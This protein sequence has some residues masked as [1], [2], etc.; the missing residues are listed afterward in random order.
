MSNM[1]YL[2]RV[3][4]VRSCDRRT[5]NRL[6]IYALGNMSMLFIFLWFVLFSSHIWFFSLHDKQIQSLEESAESLRERCLKFY[7]GCRKYTYVEIYIAFT[8][9]LVRL[10]SLWIIYMRK[11]TLCNLYVGCIFRLVRLVLRE[12]DQLVWLNNFRE[13]LDIYLFFVSL[14]FEL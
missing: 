1:L 10:L 2:I 4:F 7:K 5:F 8:F 12:Y 14:F 9:F 6:H 13:I 11:H 3:L